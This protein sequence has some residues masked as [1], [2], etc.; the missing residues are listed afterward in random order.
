MS[1]YN[2]T[3]C[4]T[5]LI[6]DSSFYLGIFDYASAANCAGMWDRVFSAAQRKAEPETWQTLFHLND[7]WID[8]A[9][10]GQ[11]LSWITLF[12]GVFKVELRLLAELPQVQFQEA[13]T[14]RFLGGGKTNRLFCPSGEIVIA[15]LGELGKASIA[16]ITKVEAGWYRVGFYCNDENEYE[17]YFLEDYSQYPAT[18]S[19]DWIFYLQRERA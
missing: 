6:H 13:E 2:A 10:Q 14:Q 1:S 9:A 18:G 8:L 15:S 7:E 12:E 11:L 3:V 19:P 4:A 17:H 16:P 5:K